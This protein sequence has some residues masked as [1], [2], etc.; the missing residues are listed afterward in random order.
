MTVVSNRNRSKNISAVKHA[1]VYK[2]DKESIINYNKTL[3]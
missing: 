3:E 2:S 1:A